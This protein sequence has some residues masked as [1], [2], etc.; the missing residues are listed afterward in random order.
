MRAQVPGQLVQLQQLYGLE[1]SEQPEVQWKRMA[2]A[3]LALTRARLVRTAAHY[4]RMTGWQWALMQ[5]RR[6]QGCR[7]CPSSL[8]LK[9]RLRQ[10]CHLSRAP[11]ERRKKQG[12]ALPLPL[13]LRMSGAWRRR[14]QS[15][16]QGEK[17][18][19]DSRS[20]C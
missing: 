9:L 3:Q 20:H 10:G 6:R 16:C 14:R 4:A 1:R 7:W 15:L 12:Q 5:R 11:P 8:V 18:R 2:M 19:G 13:L 17:A